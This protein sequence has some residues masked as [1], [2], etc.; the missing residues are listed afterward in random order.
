MIY[1]SPKRFCV[2]LLSAA[3]LLCPAAMAAARKPVTIDTLLQPPVHH[4]MAPVI[5]SPNAKR[6]AAIED[7]KLVLYDVAARQ[8]RELLPM[9]RLEALARKV[10]E[11]ARFDWT[12]RRVGEQPV[13][14]FAS[15]E[16]LLVQA[17]GDLFVVHAASAAIEQLT[18][19]DSTEYDPKLSP[20]NTRVAFRR[21][22]EVYSLE[23]S[24]KRETRLTY[25]GS[26]TRLNGQL[27]WVYP[28]EL[29]LGTAYWWSP[30]SRHLA[31]LQ[32]DTSQEPVFP[33]VDLLRARGLL[34]PERYPKAGDPN[35]VVRVGV[36][37]VNGGTTQWLDAGAAQDQL[38][39]RLAWFPDS[40]E[41][42]VL[43]LNRVQNKLELL[44]AKI[45]GGAPRVLLQEE[46]PYWINVDDTFRFLDNKQFLWSSE[47]SGHRHL[48][49]YGNDGHLRR[50]LT[51]GDWDVMSVAGVDD[52]ARRVYYIS[53]EDSPLERQ[54]Y[55]VGFDGKGKRRIT[56]GAGTFD[57][58][59]SPD[60]RLMLETFSSL[61]QPPSR[62][63][64]R[65]DGT[66]VALYAPANRAVAD[67]Y[68]LLPTELVKL[69]TQDGQLMYGRLIKPAGFDAGRRYP[70]I[71][72]VYGGPHAQTVH[73]SWAGAN[74]DQVLAHKGYLIWQV[75]N[76]GSYG[77]GHVWESAVYRNLGATELA[78]QQAGIAYLKTLGYAD[79]T[80]MGIF[81]WSYGG[82]MT[83]YSL[84][85]APGL[86]QAGVAGA[87]VTSWRNYDSIYTERYMGLPSE[88]VAAY[89]RSS[90]I[91]HAA[92]LQAKL[93]LLHNVEDDNVHFQNTLQMA[94]AL[95]KADRQFRMVIYPQ[96]SHG[97]TGPTRRHLYETIVSFLDE[98]LSRK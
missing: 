24:S 15:G 90:P 50:E 30:D 39:A 6:F 61:S 70:V 38:L 34:E 46:D 48:Y 56:Q 42:A 45:T 1:A 57:E 96:K 5:W 64:R 37:P 13:Q 55:V 14:W 19:T 4:G 87:P 3:A 54:L 92:D 33:Q 78:D 25:D 51:A 22:F 20:D 69:K 49:L 32:F 74:L 21:G 98:A 58:S 35:A 59:I 84:V 65:I 31:Y 72:D 44:A 63:L 80:R 27:D 94:D 52:A 97:V 71:V 53:T 93:L 23:L 7:K 67:E 28:E 29:E 18:A 79:T 73:N 88:N 76:R 75:D 81:G 82:Y 83:L 85:N 43:R 66:E 11:A 16:R 36:V 9:S 91:Q 17:G 95:E 77:R 2:A 68:E 47:R 10:P 62:T 89:D 8:S 40:S 26:A 60:G 12:N 86:F 41:V